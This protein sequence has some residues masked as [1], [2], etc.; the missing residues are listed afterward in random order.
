MSILVLCPF[1]IGLVFLLLSFMISFYIMDINPLTN[2]WFAYFFQSVGCL[3]TLLM[4]SVA[5][6]KLL[7]L[8]QL[9]LFIFYFA[10]C[11]LGIISPYHF[12]DTPRTSVSMFSSRSFRKPQNIKLFYVL[13]S[14][15]SFLCGVCRHLCV[16]KCVC[17]KCCALS[18]YYFFN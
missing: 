7:S 17:S 5:V 4:V 15:G 10:A 16:C 14:G 11:D 12:Q 9:P 1:L 3:V 6:P 13:D 8:R 2:I 18:I